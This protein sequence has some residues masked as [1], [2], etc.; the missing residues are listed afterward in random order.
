MQAANYFY[1]GDNFIQIR[2]NLF[3]LHVEVGVFTEYGW[4]DRGWQG[5]RDSY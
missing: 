3:K 2:A 1:F 5:G 4:Y